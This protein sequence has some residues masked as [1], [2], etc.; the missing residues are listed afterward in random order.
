[1]TQD[2]PHPE[3]PA[4][5]QDDESIAVVGMGCKLPGAED[6]EEFWNLLLRGE[7][8]HK[9]VPSD[10]FSFYTPWRQAQD[11][12]WFGNFIDDHDTFDHKFFKKSPREIAST[13]PQQRLMLQVAY[14][15]LEQA[16][17]FHTLRPEKRVGCYLGIVAV[18]YE[19]NIACDEPNAYTAVGNLRSFLAGKVSHHFGWTAPALTVDTACSSSAV[20]I[21]QACRAI[22]HGDCVTAL[23][24]GANVLTSPFWFQNLAAA[25]FLSPTGQCKPFDAAADGYCRG[26]G[27]AAVYLKKLT[28]AMEDGDHIIGT[29]PSTIITQNENCTPIFVPNSPS[30]ASLFQQ[31]I[32][33][34]HLRPEQITYVEAHGTGTAVGDPAEYEGIRQILGGTRRS[35]TKSLHLGSSKGCLGHSEQTSGVVSLIKVLLMIQKGVIP[36]QASFTKMNPAIN[37]T[38]SDHMEVDT[39][40]KRWVE[41][42]RAALVNNYGASGSNTSM[43]VTQPPRQQDYNSKFA[44]SEETTE[45]F[46]ISA[47][48]EKALISYVR[49]LRRFINDSPCSLL[50]IS[51][52]LS[53]QSNRSL[54]HS[55]SFTCNSINELDKK[56]DSVEYS[57]NDVSRDLTSP[58]RRVIFCFG[59][60][61]ATHIGLDPNL[62]DFQVFRRNLDACDK[63]ITSKG[64][65]SIY[66]AI[67]QKDPLQD[68]VHLQLM[69]F[70]LQYACAKSWIDCGIE[71]VAIVGHSFGELTGLCVSGIL[72][73]RDTIH[74][75][76]ARARIIEDYWGHEKGGM[77]AV[78]AS[79]QTVHSI[80]SEAHKSCSKEAPASIACYNNSCSFTISGSTEAIDAVQNTI[81]TVP[82]FALVRYKRLNVTNAFH[83]SLVEPLTELLTQAGEEVTFLEPKYHLE[84]AT[85]AALGDGYTSDFF[86]RHLRHPVFF[87]DAVQKLE[88]NYP[89]AVWLEAGSS[90][91]VLGL[92]K[93]ALIGDAS[94]TSFQDIRLS[95][96]NGVSNLAN[97]TMNL[98]R[99]GVRVDFWRHHQLEVSNRELLFLPPYQFDKTRHFMDIKPPPSKNETFSEAEEAET[100][101]DLFTF[102]DYQD[103]ARRISRFRINAESERFQKF[104]QGHKMARTAFVCP[105]TLQVDMAIE[106]TRWLK[107]EIAE[108]GFLPQLQKLENYSAVCTHPSKSIFLDVEVDSSDQYHWTWTMTSQNNYDDSSTLHAKGTLYYSHEKDE[109]YQDEFGKLERLVKHKRCQ[110]VLK[111]E[112]ES[113]EIMQGKNIYRSFTD[114]V[115]YSEMYKGITRLVGDDSESA[116][117]VCKA[118]SGESWLDAPVSDSFCQVA[119]IFVNCMANEIDSDIFIASGIEQ[120]IRSPQWQEAGRNLTSFDVYSSHHHSSEKLWVSDVFIFDP[121][122]GKLIEAILGISYRR[123][124]KLTMA[125]ILGRVIAEESPQGQP[126]TVEDI[127]A[128]AHMS[129]DL[130]IRSSGKDATST[131]SQYDVLSEGETRTQ[132]MILVSKLTGLQPN[133]LTEKTDLGDI[134][135]DSLLGME[136]AREIEDTFKCSLDITH[137]AELQNIGDLIEYISM[138]KSGSDVPDVA[139]EMHDTSTVST[140]T[141]QTSHT[142]L[143]SASSVTNYSNISS[144]AV[145]ET[146]EAKN[147]IYLQASLEGSSPVERKE[148]TDSL[149]R[150]YSKGFRVS[151]PPIAP[152]DRRPLRCSV[153]LTGAT[154]SLG[155][156]MAAQLCSSPQIHQVICLNRT[157]STDGLQRQYRSF[158]DKGLDVPMEALEKIRI[159]ATDTSQDRLG[160]SPADFNEL[161]SSV[162]AIVHNAW[163]MSTTRSLKGFS[164]QFQTMRNLI[165]FA[166]AA[167]THAISPRVVTFQFVSSIATIGQYP[168]NHPHVPVPEEPTTVENVLP[169]GYGEAKFVCEKLLDET[170]CRYPDHFRATSIRLGQVSGSSRSGYWNSAEHLAMLLKS[171]QT[172]GYL[173]D[174]QGSMAWTPVDSVADILRDLLTAEEAKDAVY[175]VDNPVRQEWR[176]VISTVANEFGIPPR[177]IIP[178]NAWLKRVEEFA[179]STEENPAHKVLKF[180]KEDFERMACGGLVMETAKCRKH[181]KTLARQENLGMDLIRQYVRGWKSISFLK[182]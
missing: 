10:R 138:A 15:T 45:P 39:T 129:R 57:H 153:L 67:L 158:R 80:L 133:E 8:Q 35:N 66:P 14:Q 4:I 94:R 176:E 85:R 51:F 111:G 135:L 34:A 123:I 52:N 147:D 70:T 42:F 75:I 109:T 40:P 26:E 22:L 108:A 149:I 64:L 47:L 9:E 102:V 87:S 83:S 131:T 56:L 127:Q 78:Q 161:V 93:N 110:Q 69:L 21:S 107:P 171:S 43:V 121:C 116:G 49:R 53:R 60:Q 28:N 144:R 180:L 11:R 119:G 155:A 3:A 175:H 142:P 48:D 72:S 84:T 86:A 71:P 154:G 73:L 96:V 179:G 145:Q 172:L 37:A 91:G 122:S 118:Y 162:T 50:S 54:P 1:M 141:P 137:L 74:I 76:A 2:F 24:G 151:H 178:F 5:L 115:D 126:D 159:V 106:A 95:G 166:K 113:A 59:G 140:N 29:I 157:T 173:P 146:L 150:K 12:Q 61:N 77:I 164:S 16:G 20:A 169:S 44:A 181:S 117:H 168:L 89:E 143:S 23:A 177:N 132:T 63:I 174:L 103:R 19:N 170:L 130:Q 46:W 167:A 160:L 128:K 18:D 65:A 139:V 68:T 32:D 7:S 124:S 36:P 97:S 13:D 31:T 165:D 136:L 27:I 156:H 25:S 112:S 163:P 105:A 38:A 41:K 98:W 30:L 58:L 101:L 104:I 92:A 88:A 99:Q 79:E 134:G 90:S 17:Y 82:T 55:L 152:L 148:L 125:R 81:Q 33:R 114:V 6:P 120:W 62:L 100:F 182:S